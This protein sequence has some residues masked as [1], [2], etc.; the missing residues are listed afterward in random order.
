MPHSFS[1]WYIPQFIIIEFISDKNLSFLIYVDYI[2]SYDMSN[3]L[4]ISLFAYHVNKYK[5]H[6]TQTDV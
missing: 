3:T 4:E 5:I 2:W 1:L 6:Y